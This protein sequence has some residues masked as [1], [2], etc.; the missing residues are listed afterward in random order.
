M[1]LPREFPGCSTWIGN[2]TEP[3]SLRELRRQNLEF[4]GGQGRAEHWRRESYTKNE[5]WIS[6][7]GSPLRLWLSTYLRMCVRKWSRPGKETLERSR[8]KNSDAHTRL[9]IVSM[10]TRQS[11]KDLQKQGLE[12]IKLFSSKYIPE[13]TPKNI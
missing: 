4:W 6:G 3:S 1:P 7:E 12:W 13:Q 11:E 5:L 10:L 2:P 8:Q 9:W